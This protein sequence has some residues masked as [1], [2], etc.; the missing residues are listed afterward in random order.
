MTHPDIDVLDQA[1]DIGDVRIGTG[2]FDVLAHIEDVGDMHAGPGDYAGTR[3]KAKFMEGFA[4]TFKSRVEGI[5]LRY[6]AHLSGSGD[7]GWVND[8]TYVG[9][10]GSRKPVE[11][12]SIEVSGPQ[13]ARYDVVYMTHIRD[14]GDSAWVS[15]GTFCGTRM[16]SRPVEGLAVKIVPRVPQYVT[17]V[18]KAASGSGKSLVITA[19]AD[20][21][22][23]KVSA[24]VGS[25]LQLWDR[26][27][28]KSGQGFALISKARPSLCI[29]RGPGQPTVLKDVALIDT[30]DSCVWRDDSVPGR[31]NAIN[32][33]TDWELKLNMAG[34]P[35]YADKDNTLI[36][37]PWAAGA[38]NELW[39]QNKA[40]YDLVGGSDDWALNTVSEAIYRGCYPKVFKGSLAIGRAGI[41]SVGYD[42]LT[43]PVFSLKPST[44]FQEHVREQVS[45]LLDA[46]GLPDSVG[47]TEAVATTICVDIAALTL[48]VEG[49][50]PLTANASLQ[51]TAR[52][53]TNT[54]RSLSLELILGALD[55]PEHPALASLLN[56]VFVPLLLAVLNK[57][58][59]NHIAI[60]AIDLLGIEFSAPVLGTRYPY[61][62]AATSK[63]PDGALLPPPTHWPNGK[64]F[65]GVDQTVLDSVGAAALA[66]LKP[67]GDWDYGIDIGLCDLKLHA[68]YEMHLSNP[69][70]TVTPQSG[71]TYKVAI[72]L[73]GYASFRAKC[74]IFDATPGAG[75][76][77]TVEATASVSVSHDNKIMLTFKSLDRIGL[78]WSF[79]GLPFWLDAVISQILGAFDPIVIAAVTAALHGHTFEVY[80][81]PTIDATIAGTTFQI[82]LKDLV[83]DS[84]ADAEQK[85]L[86]LVTGAADV[87]VKA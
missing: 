21:T 56:E 38:N 52:I 41:V 32:S 27:P 81:I 70:F 59:L 1:E 25:D 85:A 20:G 30:D 29:A 6:R 42:I 43:A 36:V 33:W 15:N 3:G 77:G 69:R 76:S 24:P 58:I 40:T 68:H 73:G 75:A 31:F 55:I 86:L 7:T 72:D 63:V 22:A 5:G 79:N 49:D 26:R 13:L 66:T 78:H 60:P 16:Q 67:S 80:T 8:G 10:R 53:Q 39:R 62:L 82:R 4:V 65:A 46:A 34:N 12:F 44:L 83:L 17:L 28:V 47:A 48:S 45:A 54:D 18:S 51:M 9:T 19:S 87:H 64:V 84:K 61:V 2:N 57:T 50:K 74:G 71:N 14:S 35:P 37:Y 11:G 23:V